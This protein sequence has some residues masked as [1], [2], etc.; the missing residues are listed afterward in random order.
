MIFKKNVRVREEK[1]GSVIFDTLK[2]KVFVTSKTGSDILQLVNENKSQDEIIGI[3]KERYN[4]DP[5][6]LEKDVIGF[7]DRL[8]NES[9]LI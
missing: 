5:E 1:F 6:V 2:E 8:R 4:E 3:L 7:I 9:I